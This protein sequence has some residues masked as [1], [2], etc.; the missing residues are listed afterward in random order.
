[1]NHMVEADT[2]RWSLPQRAVRTAE[3]HSFYLLASFVLKCIGSL[4]IFLRDFF[5]SLAKPQILLN[6]FVRPPDPSHT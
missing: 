3:K 2:I 5:L 4:V 1:M 6:L